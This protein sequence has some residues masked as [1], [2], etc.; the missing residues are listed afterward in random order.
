MRFISLPLCSSDIIH[1]LNFHLCFDPD[2]YTS[3]P[4]TDLSPTSSTLLARSLEPTATRRHLTGLQIPPPSLISRQPSYH[5]VR[6]P[7]P[8]EEPRRR[9]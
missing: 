6:I 3:T 1:Q 4:W 9:L 8:R 7:H 2:L 5:R